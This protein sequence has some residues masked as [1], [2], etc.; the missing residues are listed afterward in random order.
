MTKHP[1]RPYEPAQLVKLMIDIAR[2]LR[3]RTGHPAAE[4]QGKDPGALAAT[5]QAARRFCGFG[6]SV[7]E[8]CFLGARIAAVQS[9]KGPAF[10]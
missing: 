10:I 5:G 8:P 4:E 9:C 3:S 7:L 6:R 1:K 2:R